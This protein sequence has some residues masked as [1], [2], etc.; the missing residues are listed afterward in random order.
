MLY[1]RKKSTK[2]Q[3]FLKILQKS[4]GTEEQLQTM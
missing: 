4:Q 3:E 1:T 2:T